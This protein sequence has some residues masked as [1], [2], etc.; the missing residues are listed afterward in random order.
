[1]N[2]KIF[3]QINNGKYFPKKILTIKPQKEFSMKVL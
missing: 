1:M 2:M 3:S